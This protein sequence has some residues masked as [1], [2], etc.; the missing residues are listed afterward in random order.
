M[1]GVYDVNT[2][3]RIWYAYRISPCDAL[4]GLH[5][6]S[7]RIR[8]ALSNQGDEYT[9]CPKMVNLFWWMDAFEVHDFYDLFILN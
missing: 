5:H 8:P 2:L 4:S 7:K 6:A 1:R 9:L 3:V